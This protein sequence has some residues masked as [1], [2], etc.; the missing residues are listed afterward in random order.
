MTCTTVGEGSVDVDRPAMHRKGSSV[1]PAGRSLT[2][3]KKKRKKTVPLRRCCE[4]AADT[5][6][7]WRVTDG[8]WRAN[9]GGWTVTEGGWVTDGGASLWKTALK[10]GP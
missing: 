5:D 4:K 3:K 2:A 7:G 9:D 1:L 10:G 6:G 8:G